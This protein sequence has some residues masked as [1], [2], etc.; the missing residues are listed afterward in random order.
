MVFKNIRLGITHIPKTAGTFLNDVFR[1][2]VGKNFFHLYRKSINDNDSVPN[3]ET[4]LTDKDILKHKCYLHSTDIITSHY[5]LPS[6]K[7]FEIPEKIVIFKWPLTII[8][9]EF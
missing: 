6:E 8:V 4:K 2:S 7:M 1:R 9:K 3:W 5:L